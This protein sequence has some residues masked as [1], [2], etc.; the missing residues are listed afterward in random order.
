MKQNPTKKRLGTELLSSTDVV[1]KIDNL[2]TSLVYRNVPASEQAVDENQP[3]MLLS[4]NRP[5][6]ELHR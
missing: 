3:S 4:Y 5:D 2:L 1:R 6:R